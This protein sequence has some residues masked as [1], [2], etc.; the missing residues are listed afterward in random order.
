[1]TGLLVNIEL[2]RTWKEEAKVHVELL[3]DMGLG[4]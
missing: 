4:L 3:T 1:M 2:E